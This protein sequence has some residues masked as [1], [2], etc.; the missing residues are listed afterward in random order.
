MSN[1][2]SIP[3]DESKSVVTYTLLSDG[4]QLSKSYQVISLMITKELNRI[5]TARIVVLDGEASR[6]TFEISN[7]DD[8][9]PGKEIEI[10]IG[11][12]NDEQTVFK[13]L[14]IKHGIKVRNNSSVLVVDCKDKASKMTVSCKSRYFYEST[15]S[16][17]IEALIDNHGLDKEVESTSV[18][19][20]Q[21]VQYNT[22]D[23]DMMLCRAEANGLLVL[24]NDGV[25][26][27]GKP[28]LSAEAVL[29]VQYGATIHDL[30]AE[31]DARLQFKSLKGSTWNY[32]DQE[33]VDDI[34]A[35]DPGVPQAGNLDLQSLSD[36]IGEEEFRLQH[37]G[38][39][40]E[41]ELQSWLNGALMKH[42]L[43]K[44]RGKVTTDGTAAVEPGM[45]IEIKGI[46]ERFEGK[47][48]VS[49]LMQTL[50][51]GDW[52]TTF[53]FGINPEWFAE[54]Y[55][56]FQPLAGGLLPPIQ[57][58]QVGVVTKLDGDPDGDDRIQVRLPVIHNEEE[59]I[60]SRISTLDA[61]NQRGTYF[62]PEIDD[63]V[64]VG[65]IN[66]DPRHAVILGMMHSSSYPAPEA[67]SDDNHKKGYVTREGMKLTFDDEKLS[68]DLETPG[69]NKIQITEE[70]SKIHIECQNGNK[71]VMDQDGITLESV[72][73]IVLKAS[74]DLKAEA[75][76]AEITGSASAKMS[77]SG[78]EVSLS[79]TATLK[80][81][82]VNI[83]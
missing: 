33:L 64:V 2:R 11:Y 73:D 14:V 83:N 7:T 4:T 42:H 27:V 63:E 79:G 59:G 52:K 40:Q 81:S 60:W 54:Q 13:G 39:L 32:S 25:I 26:K 31:I 37:S 68:V 10:K 41:P 53:Q 45:M 1:E 71:L 36:V 70:D 48:F 29:T 6:E 69:G 20:Q 65:F 23:W 15:D 77:A 57:G 72:K 62:R 18:T 74:G 51:N 17:V 35:E 47:L 5:P 76:N 50:E 34:E 38:K 3:S 43:A 61:G 12:R 80:G 21:V 44:I 30:D 67:P 78:A 66:N 75:T 46:G 8:F 24:A 22:T 16:D 49:G 55:R 82:V 56:V 28:D 19:H 58:L 9:V